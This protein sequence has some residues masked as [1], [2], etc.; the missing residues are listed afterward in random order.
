MITTIQKQSL[1]DK[2]KSKFTNIKPVGNKKSL[3][4]CFEIWEETDKTLLTF[5]YN[6]CQGSTHLE[7]LTINKN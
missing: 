1:I 6:D 4:K 3:D 5:W 2:A 7:T